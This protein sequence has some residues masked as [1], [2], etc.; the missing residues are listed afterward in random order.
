M[1][2]DGQ[3]L[4]NFMP[5]NYVM[6][7]VIA[8][9][10]GLVLTGFTGW[11][12]SL[13]CKGQTTIECLEK[14][15][16]L[17]PLRKSMQKQNLGQQ[18][19]GAKQTFGQQL[20]EIHANAL[21][22][23]TREE[24]GEERPSPVVDLEQGLPAREAL[25]ANYSDLERSRERERYEDYLDEQ[26]SEKLPN[27]FD[28]G[29]K[30]NLLHLFGDKPTSWLLPICNTSGD[31]WRWEPSPKW[32]EAREEI[33]RQREAKWRDQERR[34]SAAG[35]GDGVDFDDP[36]YEDHTYNTQR[37]QPRTD[38]RH[39]LPPTTT[40]NGVA[41]VPPREGKRSPGK[42]D[43]ILGREPDRHYIDNETFRNER[44][45][46]GMSMRTMRRKSSLEDRGE[47][48]RYDV[49]SDD[50]EEPP[51]GNWGN[52]QGGGWYGQQGVGRRGEGKEGGRAEVEWRDWE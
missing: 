12:I 3:Y 20:A 37:W 33:R 8:G 24:E 17:S 38:S 26:G 31:G 16:Y 34:E 6:L 27:A 41:T 14:T 25:L 45:R 7:C 22:G 35:W 4:E 39:Y 52:R 9:I 48:D 13:A 47:E 29:W 43:Q 49:S 18:N 32:L 46:S 23:I 15:R 28:L 36:R 30:R 51:G 50:E 40:H 19:G 44:P 2:S 1:L 11:H 10:I 5:V 42:A 21:P